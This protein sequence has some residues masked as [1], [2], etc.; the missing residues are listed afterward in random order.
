MQI[1]MVHP[2]ETI[3]DELASGQHTQAS[4][5]VTY[6]FIIQQ[7]G[8]SAPWAK[9]NA[10]ITKRWNGKTALKRVKKM[11]WSHVLVRER[12]S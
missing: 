12:P 3:V 6:A 1:E 7:L 10:A 2:V 4:V 8:S 9:I 11:A 5:A